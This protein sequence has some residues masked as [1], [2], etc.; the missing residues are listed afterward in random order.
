FG[1]IITEFNPSWESGRIPKYSFNAKE[2]DEENGMY[3]YSARYYAP[4]TFISRDPMFEKKPFISPYTYCRNNPIILV[5]PDGRDEYEFT[6][7]GEMKNVEKT[8]FDSFHKVD[9][10]GKRVE[11]GSLILDKKVVTGQV[12]LKSDAGT[13]VNYLKVTGDDEAK[14]IF[15]HLANNS[16][17]SKTEYGLTRIGDKNGSEGKNMIGANVKHT[18]GSTAA[19]RTLFDRGYTIREANHNHPNGSNA[20]SDGDVRVAGIIQDKFPKATFYNYTKIHGYT[21]YDKNTTTNTPFIM[22]PEFHKKP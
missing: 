22:L 6:S 4:P 12:T 11:G 9:E 15:E 18:E 5:D 21:P 13:A 8:D 7:S 3:Y 14:Q 1:E 17:E 20:S 16:V 19:N 10:N 2:L